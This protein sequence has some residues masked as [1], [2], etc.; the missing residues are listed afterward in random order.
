[1]PRRSVDR[2]ISRRTGLMKSRHSPWPDRAGHCDD[3]STI[4][5]MGSTARKQAVSYGN[6]G[7]WL[8][9]WAK[10]WMIGTA[11]IF[12]HWPRILDVY[13]SF[14]NFNHGIG[15]S[16]P[17]EILLLLL[18]SQPFTNWKISSDDHEISRIPSNGH[19][20]RHRGI[21]LGYTLI[22]LF[23]TINWD[24]IRRLIRPHE[25]SGPVLSSQCNE[26]TLSCRQSWIY[27][28]CLRSSTN[29]L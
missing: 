29:Y 22:Q 2:G 26:M 16:I 19:S 9:N 8:G 11:D 21:D 20:D 10:Q 12:G 28:C 15:A 18:S 4:I 5:F 7:L 27:T 17:W 13:N 25:G 3:S 24:V 6:R 14:L 23:E 1:M